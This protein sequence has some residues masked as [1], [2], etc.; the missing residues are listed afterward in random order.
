MVQPECLRVAIFAHN[1]ERAIAAAVQSV[2]AATPKGCDLKAFV[3]INGCT[4]N[5][6]T[7]VDRLAKSFSCV[8]PV[9]IPYPDKQH[10]DKCHAWNTY[11]YELAD[12]SECHF[13]MDGDGRCSRDSL[14]QMW[15]TLMGQVNAQAIAG[16]PLS[17]R[18]CK[19]YQ[20]LVTK[21]GWLFGNL[22]AIKT[23]RLRRLQQASLRMPLGLIFEDDVATRFVQARQFD[24]LTRY[25]EQVAYHPEAG[26]VF[27]SLK[28]YRI[29]DWQ[30]YWRR[31]GTYCLGNLQILKL[32]KILLTALPQ[33]MDDINRSILSDLEATRLSAHQLRPR[34]VRARLRRMYSTTDALCR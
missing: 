25:S 28:W 8:I 24:S 32:D 27:D 23:S 34:L 33:T 9:V 20:G 6:K 11:V 2:I 19:M 1:E 18:N 16:M 26:F 31:L 30:T 17:G 13:F 5:T 29:R 10:P 15:R 14:V 7:V 3:L 4:D 21:Y 12:D 22:Y